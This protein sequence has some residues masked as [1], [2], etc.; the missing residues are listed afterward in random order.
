MR[1]FN[2]DRSVTNFQI[3]YSNRELF[4]GPAFLSHYFVI[5]CH[6][7]ITKKIFFISIP[8]LKITAIADKSSFHEN[9]NETIDINT[10]QD[11]IK[12]RI[13]LIIL[14]LLVIDFF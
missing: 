11:S 2:N 8:S 12:R 7:F 3:H 14:V 4:I 6:C 1:L 5:V 10:K 13:P 9:I